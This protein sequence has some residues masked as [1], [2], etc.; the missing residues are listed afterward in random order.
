VKK[1]SAAV[2][3]NEVAKHAGVSIATVSRAINNPETVKSSTKARIDQAVKELGYVPNAWARALM[4]GRSQTVGAVVPTLDN[5][6][7]AKGLEQFQASMSQ[8][9][10][11]VLVAS[12][13][14]DPIV[15][16]RAIKTLLMR[17]AEA[18]ALFGA[19]QTAS[20]IRLLKDRGTPYIHLATLSPIGAGHACGFD[21]TKAIQEGVHHLVALGHRHIGVIAGITRDNDRATQRVLG[22]KAALEKYG[23]SISDDHI[24][25]STYDIAAARRAFVD[26]RQRAPRMTG[27]VCGQDV[28][29][30]GAIIQAQRMGILIPDDL[31][32]V[33]FDDL[34]MSQHIVPSLTTIRYDAGE[35]WSRGAA[36]LL[37]R[38][39]GKKVPGRLIRSET[40]LV[41][42]ESTGKPRK[43]GRP[44]R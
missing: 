27:I 39:R 13:N 8:E 35:I 42:R 23:L 26:L 38:L 14:Y 36:N 30:Y 10:Y 31:S 43:T 20:A 3:I 21:N 37:A 5:A 15:E 2:N 7:F 19:S 1:I 29:A 33:G 4:L 6:I 25:E 34:E 40:T 9:G 22:V 41:V 32:I 44:K 24:V 16:E 11:Q 28:L 17:G 12:S 18:L